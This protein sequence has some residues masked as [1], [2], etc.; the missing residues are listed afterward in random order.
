LLIS[1]S[2]AVVLETQNAVLD[3]YAAQ[4]VSGAHKK[5]TR[6]SLGARVGPPYCLRG[7]NPEVGLRSVRG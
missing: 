7:G 3:R 5:Q 6:K 1:M 2:F 4:A